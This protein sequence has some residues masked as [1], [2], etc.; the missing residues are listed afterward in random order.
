MEDMGQRQQ[1]EY[2]ASGE[3]VMMGLAV[4]RLPGADHEGARWSRSFGAGCGDALLL[5]V[6]SVKG[7]LKSHVLEHLL[8]SRANRLPPEGQVTQGRF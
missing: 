3:L 2:V 4:T 1:W 8:P 7:S 5:T 6:V